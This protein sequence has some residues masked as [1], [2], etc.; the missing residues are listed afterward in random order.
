MLWGGDLKC[1]GIF[2]SFHN[3]LTCGR[4]HFSTFHKVYVFNTVM[5]IDHSYIAHIQCQ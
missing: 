2:F 5:E 1:S 4:G 3:H